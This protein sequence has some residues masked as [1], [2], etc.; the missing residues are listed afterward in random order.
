V[1]PLVHR[2][3][4]RLRQL[5]DSRR[6]DRSG[7]RSVPSPYTQ[8]HGPSAAAQFGLTA[9]KVADIV[10]L[11]GSAPAGT[12]VHIELDGEDSTDILAAHRFPH[13]DDPHGPTTCFEVTLDM[14][15]ANG[16]RRGRLHTGG[17]VGEWLD[18]P[19]LPAPGAMAGVETLHRCPACASSELVNAGR[20]QHLTMATCARCGLMMTTPRPVED[21]TLMRYSER[22]FAEEYLPA[23]QLTPELTRHLDSILDFAEPAKVASATLFELGIGGGN[24]LNRAA[25]RGWTVSGTDVNPASVAH[26]TSQGL[27]AWIENSDHAE[28]LGGPYGAVISEMSLEHVRCPEHFCSLAATALVPGGRL[29]IY[30]VSA[31]GDSFEHSGMASALVGPAEHLFLF[32]AGSLVSLCQRAGLRVETVWRNHTADE[33]G[34]V[35]VKRRD[36]GSPAAPST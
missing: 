8:W 36:V 10:L 7:R 6:F 35:A 33:I 2:I 22:Y 16:A 18:L 21:H 32:S 24:L 4:R 11:Q 27:H 25:D 26:A 19:A 31:E 20:R 5:A 34:V 12:P 29:V 9:T 15:T 23:Q 14:T 1:N 30:T 3:A 17:H 28:S 13:P